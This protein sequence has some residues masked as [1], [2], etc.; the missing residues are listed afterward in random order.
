MLP[1]LAQTTDVHAET[2]SLV[3]SDA[4]R[5]SLDLTT[6][7][8]TPPPPQTTLLSHISSH[9]IG[10]GFLSGV[11]GLCISLIPVSLAHGSLSA[12]RSVIGAV[13]VVWLVLT[14]IVW[15]FLPTLAASTDEPGV[16]QKVREGWIRVKGLFDG[17]EV[18]RLRV[19][20]WYLLAS[21]LL[22]DGKQNYAHRRFAAYKMLKLA[23][24]SIQH[25]HRNQY[26]LR[27]HNPRHATLPRPPR[28]PTHATHR[29]MLGVPHAVHPTA[30]RNKRDA[31][32]SR[33][34]GDGVGVVSLGFGGSADERGD[35]CLCGVVWACTY[36]TYTSGCC[37][38]HVCSCTV[39]TTPS[40]DRSSWNSFQRF[41]FR[42]SPS[43]ATDCNLYVD[44]ATKHASSVC[45]VS[46]TRAPPSSAL[47][48]LRSSPT[49]PARCAMR[50]WCWRY[51]WR[52]RCQCCCG[53]LTRTGGGG[54]RECMVG[55]GRGL[56]YSKGFDLLVHKSSS[57]SSGR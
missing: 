8:T 27:A 28:R 49:P 14:C 44:R 30:V 55:S 7:P 53:G 41:V 37:K 26:P 18:R 4:L 50:L 9:G 34:R 54:M 13:G 51:C 10:I 5:S 35:V 47:R 15:E 1:F 52:Y 45:S 38:A 24:R 22:Q 46:P 6:L 12:M 29:R 20:Y 2:Q 32:D 31:R 56:L 36:A 43:S 48:P 33:M 57:T 19:T 17:D 39:H 42:F 40:R 23:E 16:W 11:T 3:P 25:H 21:A